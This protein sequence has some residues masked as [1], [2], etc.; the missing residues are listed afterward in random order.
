MKTVANRASAVAGSTPDGPA[1]FLPP[2]SL[3][4]LWLKAFLGLA[5]LATSATTHAAGAGEAR[6][7]RFLD[8]LKTLRAEFVQSL[9]EQDGTVLEE[10]EG[11]LLVS[12]PGKFRL[13][14]RAPHQQLY[15]ADGKRIWAY[16]P[17]LK[18][19][20]VRPQDEALGNTPALLLSG[21]DPFTRDFT[22]VELGDH[23]GFTWV[24]LRPKGKEGNFQY[25]RF[26]L[27]GETLRAMEMVDGI[28]QTTR[29]Y[30]DRITRNPAIPA[31]RFTFTPPK[32]VDVVGEGE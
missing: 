12:R 31:D 25:I 32:G 27:E 5:L 11:T 13:E 17:D 22:P 18:Q 9:M 28:G 3:W 14:Y 23:E 15:V 4:A 8:G 10:S 26:A 19:V 21:T 1:S 30:F 6:L 2:C 29:L 24:E 7:D 20:T 16:D